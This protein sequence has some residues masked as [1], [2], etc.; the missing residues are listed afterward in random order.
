MSYTVLGWHPILIGMNK[1]FA[2]DIN[3]AKISWNVISPFL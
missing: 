1:G 2:I 3:V